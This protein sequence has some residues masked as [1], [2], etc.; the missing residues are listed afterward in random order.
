MT[1]MLNVLTDRPD[2]ELLTANETIAYFQISLTTLRR[3][4]KEGRLIPVRVNGSRRKYFP[5]QVIR[6]ALNSE[7]AA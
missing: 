1:I 6:D 7:D 3:W 4:E 2:H 5:V